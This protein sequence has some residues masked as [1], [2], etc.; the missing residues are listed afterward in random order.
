M[1]LPDR[2][3]LGPGPS[4]VS[5]RVL[6][7]LSSPILSHLDPALVA[8]LDDTRARLGRVFRT[9]DGVLSLLVSGTGTSGMETCVANLAS[10]GT[11]ALVVV[12]GYFGDR[13]AQMLQRY[14]AEVQR[15]DGDWGRAIDPAAVA[16]ALERGR[17]DLVAVVHAETSTGV[18]NPI[19]EIASLARAHDA[20]TLVDAVTSLGAMPLEIAA[21]QIDACYSC[22]QKGLGAPSGMS[23]V[24][25][26]PRAL[27]RRV[28]PRSFYFDL[29]LLE[30]YWLRRK[31]HHTLCS[32][33]LIAVRE[34]LAIVEE[35][36]LEHRW[37]RH[38]RCHLALA[39]GLSAIGVDLLPPED[40]RLWNLNAVRVPAHLPTGAEAGVRKHLLED[41]GIEIGAGLGPLAG[42]IWRVG[43][44]GA[45]ATPQIVLQFLAAFE[46]ALAAHGYELIR[47]SAVGAASEALGT[48]V[49]ASP[50]R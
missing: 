17:A 2:L 29:Q 10:P 50:V 7:A 1:N 4:P 34:A 24:A 18:C 37:A 6:R 9:G 22:S 3:L 5:G 49:A 43:I 25:F 11:R 32:S 14:G 31:Y 20:L 42:R 33:L 8:A 40:E 48:S 13:I 38:R 30:E 44:M 21:W 16:A 41:A 27:E 15:V 47:G 19:R 46:R 36:G 39:A 26:G 23:P 45:G 28:P 35:E 12:N